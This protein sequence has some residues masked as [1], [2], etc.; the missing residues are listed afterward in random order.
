[1]GVIVPARLELTGQRFGRLVAVRP[2]GRRIYGSHRVWLCQCDCGNTS[3]VTANSL[4]KGNTKSCGCLHSG[5]L[6]KP[7]RTI[8]RDS[9]PR[10]QIPLTNG[11]VAI[12]DDEDYDRVMAA[13]PWFVKPSSARYTRYAQHHVR[14]ASGKFKKQLLHRFIL[15]VTDPAVKVDH[16]DLDGLNCRRDNLRICTHTQNMHNR[17]KRHPSSSSSQYKGVRRTTNK[18]WQAIIKANGKTVHLGVFTDEY[19]A[20]R[21]YDGAAIRL[22]GEFARLNFPHV[23]ATAD[24]ACPQVSQQP[25]PPV[26]G[27]EAA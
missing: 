1:M 24:Q 22:H 9:L 23:S 15:A 25:I 2:T 8:E 14:D 3:E 12:V 7:N 10:P 4:R 11:Y 16:K 6:A 26:V 20:A 27:K 5:L 13:G 19:T 18:K 21:A 17:P